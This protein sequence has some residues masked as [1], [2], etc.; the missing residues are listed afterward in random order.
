MKHVDEVRGY[1]RDIF[2]SPESLYTVSG[3]TALT[4]CVVEAV[5]NDWLEN[6]PVLSLRFYYHPYLNPKSISELSEKGQRIYVETTP[7]GVE[8]NLS[9]ELAQSLI[10]QIKIKYPDLLKIAQESS[11]D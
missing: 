5:E 3:G 8:L 10:E 4:N 11:S 6:E 2:F 7:V 9:L 1:R